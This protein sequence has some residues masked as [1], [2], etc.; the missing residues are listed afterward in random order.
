M[1]DIRKDSYSPKK[2]D[3]PRKKSYISDGNKG[4]KTMI[5]QLVPCSVI[6]PG[7]YRRQVWVTGMFQSIA[8]G[9]TNIERMR[10]EL[11]DIR[12]FDP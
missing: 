10:K 1:S 9:E 2:S 5:P 11:A 3:L 8:E 12:T 4:K 6:S 7:I